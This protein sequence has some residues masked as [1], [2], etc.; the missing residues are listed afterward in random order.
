MNE[1]EERKAR[2]LAQTAALERSRVSVY[3]AEQSGYAQ[4][5]K[6]GRDVGL[7]PGI[8]DQVGPMRA[9]MILERELGPLAKTAKPQLDQLAKLIRSDGDD[10]TSWD[11]A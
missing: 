7:Q 3:D 8:M 5:F 11:A 10:S 4:G 6:D 9:L 2:H 1:A